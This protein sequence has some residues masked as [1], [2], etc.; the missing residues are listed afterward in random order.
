[1]K[2]AAELNITV[3]P[4]CGAKIRPENKSDFFG[5]CSAKH[6]ELSNREYAEKQRAERIALANRTSSVLG[7]RSIF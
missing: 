5:Y 4:Q 1:M 6:L 2:T 3:C 7:T